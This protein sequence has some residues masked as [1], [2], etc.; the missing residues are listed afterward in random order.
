MTDQT[1]NMNSMHARIL[2]AWALGAL[3]LIVATIYYG[4]AQL[5]LLLAF[6]KTNASPVWPPSGIAEP[7]HV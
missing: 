4:S 6:Q 2:P 7:K 1:P 5:G 3:L